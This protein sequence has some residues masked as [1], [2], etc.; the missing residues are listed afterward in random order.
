MTVQDEF[1]PIVKNSTIYWIMHSPAT[2]GLSISIDGKVAT[3]SKNGKIYYARIQ[4]PAEATFS[5]TNRSTNSINYLSETKDIFNQIMLNKNGFNNY[6][7][8][9]EIKL[10]N[11]SS[12]TNI[13]VDFTANN[14][15]GNILK[16]LDSWTSSN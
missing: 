7:G 2:D 15:N 1:T 8:K 6:Y 3:L 11:V 5:L 13:S 12:S 10:T 9:L 4:S 16:T 14:M